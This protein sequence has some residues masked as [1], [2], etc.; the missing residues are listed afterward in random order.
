MEEKIERRKLC[1][2]VT[3]RLLHSI[4]AG[5]Y[6][7]GGQLPS[8]REL[9]ARY[10]VGR[11]AVRE[12]LQTLDRMGVIRI[13][14]G[15]PARLISM[16]PWSFFTL[17]DGPARHLLRISPQ[18]LEHLSEARLLFEAGM[19]RLAVQ[20]GTRDDVQRLQS[21]LERMRQCAGDPKKFVAADMAFHTTIA[22]FA[23]NPI[24]TALSEFM[25]RWLFQFY[26]RLVRVPG[27]EKLTISEHEQVY[28]RIAARD[29]EGAVRAMT[30]HLK[31]ANPHYATYLAAATEAPKTRA[32]KTRR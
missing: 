17:M 9:A 25:L 3:D 1:D 21:S 32:K 19:V 8:E 29:E 24:Y 14:H 15:E 23:R 5:E 12:A 20:R 10:G 16:D 2:E 30:D 7:L 22:S 13:T 28:E 4:E 26:P 18:T 27:A 31:R 11:P 6:K